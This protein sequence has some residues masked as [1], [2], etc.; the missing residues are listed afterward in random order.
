MKSIR[1][2]TIVAV[3]TTLVA[4]CSPKSEMDRFIDDLMSKMTLEEKLGQMNLPT[5]P[6]N[7]V[8]GNERCENILE[9]IRAGKVGAIL[10]TYGYDNILPYQKTAVEESVRTCCNLEPRSHRDGREACSSRS[11]CRRY[12]LDI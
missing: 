9:N 6:S 10:N 11:Y 1:L 12:Q 7:I 8:T 5:C 3:F 2:F 4:G